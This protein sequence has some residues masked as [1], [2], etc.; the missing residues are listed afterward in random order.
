MR[1]II[2][3]F[4]GSKELFDDDGEDDEGELVSSSCTTILDYELTSLSS[5]TAATYSITNWIVAQ[6]SESRSGGYA[7]STSLVSKSLR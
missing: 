1:S 3:G 4:V 7:E 6:V 2:N 5:E